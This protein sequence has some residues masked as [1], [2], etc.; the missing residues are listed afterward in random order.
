MAI[1]ARELAHY[2]MGIAA[3]SE[4]RLS[5]QGQLVEVGA[6][7]PFFF[8]SG[9]PKAKQRNAVVTFA[10]RNDIMGR[11]PCLPQRINDRLRS[12]RLPLQR[13]NFATII[14]AY[15]PLMTSSDAVKDKFYE[16][17]HNL[18]GTGPKADKLIVLGAFNDHSLLLL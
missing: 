6:G 2:K 16:D 10:I 3:L 18:F 4:T 15:A 17:L 11:L 14:S 12:L 5:E 7:Y 8:W 1:V 13:V 9:R